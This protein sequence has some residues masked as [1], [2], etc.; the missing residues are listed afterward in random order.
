MR[1]STLQQL[2]DLSF[3]KRSVTCPRA[4]ELPVYLP[5]AF[6]LAMQGR[7]ILSL[8]ERGLYLYTPKKTPA[9]CR[10]RRRRHG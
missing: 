8:M 7:A 1:I 5:A 10:N 6:V 9:P 3:A 2:E 4:R